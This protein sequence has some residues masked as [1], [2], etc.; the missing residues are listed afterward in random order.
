MRTGR[1][2]SRGEIHK[3]EGSRPLLTAGGKL[4]QSMD[5]EMRRL[6]VMMIQEL[7]VGFGEPKP[8]RGA[9]RIK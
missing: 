5:L 1:P 6:L 2:R 3:G 9:F 8:R 7:F 4:G